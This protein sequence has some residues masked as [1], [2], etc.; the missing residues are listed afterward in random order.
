M[1]AV[2]TT[3]KTSSIASPC[4]IDG[5]QRRQRGIATVPRVMMKCQDSGQSMS[6]VTVSNP[7]Q[8]TGQVSGR[9]RQPRRQADWTVSTDRQKAAPRLVPADCGVADVS[10]TAAKRSH[11]ARLGHDLPVYEPHIFL[12]M[13]PL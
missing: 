2:D 6:Q 3:R 13:S 10:A 7:V 8:G 4:P 12:A 5:A 1:I 11:L 9:G